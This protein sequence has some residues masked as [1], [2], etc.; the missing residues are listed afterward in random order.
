MPTNQLWEDCGNSIIVV[1]PKNHEG[2][3]SN[4]HQHSPSRLDSP[5]CHMNDYLVGCSLCIFH[6]IFHWTFGDKVQKCKPGCAFTTQ[7]N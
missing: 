7:R 6:C 2:N 5:C 1:L 4:C 3:Q